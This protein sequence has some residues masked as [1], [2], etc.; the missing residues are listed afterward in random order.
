MKSVIRAAF[1]VLWLLIA[2]AFLTRWW[3][4]SPSATVIPD[5]PQ[6]FWKWLIDLLDAHDQKS[7]VVIWVGLFSSFIVVSILTGIGWFLWRH[8]KKC[9]SKTN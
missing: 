6:S 3:M 9:V 1:I 2:S 4:V 8:I 7:I 5:F